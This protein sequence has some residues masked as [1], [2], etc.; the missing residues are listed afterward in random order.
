MTFLT[1]H[2]SCISQAGAARGALEKVDM[3]GCELILDSR[4]LVS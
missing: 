2:H 4:L 1:I 3:V